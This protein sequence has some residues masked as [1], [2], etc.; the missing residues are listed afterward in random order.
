[1]NERGRETERQAAEFLQGQGMRIVARN[2]RCRFGEIDLVARDGST[3]VFV[4]VRARASRA[5]G[6]AAESIDYAKRR[7]LVAAANLY[8]AAR[9]LD[10]ACRFDAV[11]IEADGHMRW[12]RDAFRAD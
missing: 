5:F 12:V 1:M 11:L 3:L 6:G 10:A 4:E 2:W 7:K 9:K 8:L